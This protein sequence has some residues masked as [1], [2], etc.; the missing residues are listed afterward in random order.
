MKKYLAYLVEFPFLRNI[1]LTFLALLLFVLFYE[2]FQA[3]PQFRDLLTRAAEEQAVRVATHLSSHPS[4]KESLLDSPGSIPEAWSREVSLV[5]EDLQIE[6]VKVFSKSG[7]VVFSTDPE[8]VGKINT[9]EYFLNNVASGEIFSKIVKKNTKSSEGRILARTVVETYVPIMRDDIFLGSFEIYYDIATQQ[10][11]MDALLTHSSMNMLLMVVGLGLLA[12]VMVVRAAKEVHLREAIKDALQLSEEKFRGVSDS[13]K[14]A[15]V[16]MDSLG[17][18]ILWNRAAERMFGYSKSET[19]GHDMHQIVTAERFWARAKKGVRAFAKTGQG[20]K[21]V[22]H[23]VEVIGR[24]KNGSEFPVEVS[25]SAIHL[26][27]EWHAIG[28]LRDITQRKISEE[29]TQEEQQFSKSVIES[30]SGIF[31]LFDQKGRMVR[32]NRY[33]SK[34]T[35]YSDDDLYQKHALDFIPE[36]EH[37]MVGERIRAVFES[38]YAAIEGHLLGKTGEK[39]PFLFTGTRVEIG[40]KQFL[41]G[42]GVDITERKLVEAVL[43]KSEER[44][45]NLFSDALEMI[46]IVDIHGRIVDVNPI[47]VTTLGYTYHELLGISLLEVIHPD[48]RD[49]T[50]RKLKIVLGGVPITGYQT[51]LA[52]RD[53]DPVHVEVNAVPQL[54]GGQVVGARAILRDITKRKQMERELRLAKEIAEQANMAKSDFLSSMSHEI[55]TPMNAILGM[56]EVLRES[57]LSSEQQHALKVLNNAGSNL[58]ALINDILDLSKIEAGQLQMEAVSFDLHELTEGTYQILQQQAHSKGVDYTFQ[59]HM[60]H[61]YPVM[62]DPQRL[63]QVL[64]NLLG[65]A[66]K[67]T[68]QGGVTFVV[69]PLGEARIQCTISDTGIGI[70]EA[71]L[72][73]I[74]HPFKQAE[75]SISRRFGG[76]GLGLSISSRLALAMEG[77]IQVES[78]LGVG[79]VFRFTACFPR[80]EKKLVDGASTKVARTREGKSERKHS[81]QHTSLN[82]LLVDDA[83]DN[84][85]VIAAFLRK[86][87]HRVSKAVNGEEAVR[88]FQ[89]DNYDLVLMDMRM[90]VL[91]GYGATR[92]IRAWEREQGRY[93]TPIIALTADAMLEDIKKTE[94]VG[95]N[96]HLTKPIGKAHLI[97]IIGRFQPKEVTFLSEACARAPAH[98]HTNPIVSDSGG[99]EEQHD[100]NRL[101]NMEVFDELH[102]DLEGDIGPILRLFVGKLPTYLDTI[103][104]AIETGDADALSQVAHTFKGVVANF[105]AD[106]L[107]GYASQLERLGKAGQIPEDGKLWAAVAAEAEAVKMEVTRLLDVS[108]K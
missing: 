53:G 39:T 97:D 30:L 59:F 8:D 56:A 54:E 104:S 26:Q 76:T 70:P 1:L 82:I 14:D 79:S 22:G 94:E 4:F 19:L 10:A 31:Y 11:R 58:L 72:G 98:A 69:E 67:F 66:V 105:G 43:K 75:D 65:N 49:T 25:A 20:S 62:G 102:Q 85:I 107:A 24:R 28:I 16:M 47:H 100:E 51:A 5:S 101:I 7:K 23:T 38:G 61:P 18:I 77:D 84:R 64:L 6:K 37:A 17:R 80:S 12:T 34:I 86:T 89:S 90:P 44:Y 63:R 48:Y 108:G 42:T 88:A 3:F 96:M 74:F 35:G 9:Y 45:R 106:R 99:R 68:D 52:K 15:I 13:A 78:K 60:D 103:S 71:Q 21:V 32:W 57:V 95:C 40:G 29:K 41:S 73:D 50:A 87:A 33:F 36:D 46:H 2:Q 91:D 81:T 92:Q 93:P 27:G 83:E 55:R